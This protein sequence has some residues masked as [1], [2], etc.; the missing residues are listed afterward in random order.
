[1]P[2]TKIDAFFTEFPWLIKYTS[3]QDAKCLYV[4]RVDDSILTQY[5]STA[6]ERV[7]DH[8]LFFGHE[9]RILEAI[10]RFLDEGGNELLQVGRWELVTPAKVIPAKPA[11]WF[12]KARP[13]V[14]V[15]E[16]RKWRHGSETIESALKRLGEMCDEKNKGFFILSVLPSS[17]YG[18]LVTIYKAP[19]GYN[20]ISWISAEHERARREIK[21]VCADIDADAGR[22]TA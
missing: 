11:C 3:P 7:Y 8:D 10:V 12:R 22:I 16:K 15:P 17:Y 19:K 21:A 13:A 9:D 2:Q 5:P 14:E 1:M 20:L 18:S 6:T 4:K